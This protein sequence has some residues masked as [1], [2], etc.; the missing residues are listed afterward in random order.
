MLWRDP[1]RTKVGQKERKATR[2]KGALLRGE[3]ELG[4]RL[5]E[6]REKGKGGKGTKGVKKKPIAKKKSIVMRG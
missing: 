6:S 3:K 4:G 5:E 2:T 1:K